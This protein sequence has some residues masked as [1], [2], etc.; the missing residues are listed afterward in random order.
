MSDEDN[1]FRE[2]EE[3]MRRERLAAMWDKYGVFVI[4]AAAFFVIV[5]GGYNV[6][7]W[8][9]EKR[10]AEDGQA[11]YEA[12]RLLD[13]NNTAEALDAFGKLAND[14]RS[15][16]ETLAHLKMAAI[17]A[18]EGRKGEAVALYDQVSKGGADRVLR[19]FASLQAAALRLD[20]AEPAEMQQR[21][22]GLNNDNNSWRYSARELLALSA[23]RSGNVGESEKLFT[24]ILGDPSAPA[25]IRR[26]AEA[27]LALMVKT[28]EKVSSVVVDEKES[29]T[30]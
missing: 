8:W 11:Y 24:Q 15:G 26:R 17:H 18:R 7:E 25:E 28:P 2:V 29:Q 14:G 6:N 4:G 21:L 13:G 27:M 3:D 1:I 30:Q 12:S 22:S 5:V 10:S 16:Y 9:Q 19:D 23:F 20:E